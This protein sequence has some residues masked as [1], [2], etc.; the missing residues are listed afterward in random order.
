S[1]LLRTCDYF[2]NSGGWDDYPPQHAFRDKA[3]VTPV[4]SSAYYIRSAKI[5]RL[6]AK[7]LGLKKEVKEYEQTIKQLSNE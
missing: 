1:G 4:V 6:A 3:S 2:Y 7:E 5:L